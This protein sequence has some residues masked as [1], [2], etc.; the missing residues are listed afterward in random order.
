MEVLQ[1]G[2]VMEYLDEELYWYYNNFYVQLPRDSRRDGLPSKEH[3]LGSTESTIDWDV[4]GS[5][6]QFSWFC[7][8]LSDKPRDEYNWN[9]CVT[10]AYIALSKR[11]ADTVPSDTYWYHSYKVKPYWASAYHRTAVIGDHIFYSDG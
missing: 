10:I 4:R 11:V 6:S 1:I 8:G 3:L 9:V 7:D 2:K 5:R